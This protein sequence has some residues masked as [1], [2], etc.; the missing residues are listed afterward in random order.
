MKKK[1]LILFT[2]AALVFPSTVFAATKSGGYVIRNDSFTWAISTLNVTYNSSTKKVYGGDVEWRYKY[3]LGKKFNT[4]VTKVDTY[5]CSAY[6]TAT[7]GGEKRSGNWTVR[8][9]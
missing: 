2:F 3:P 7:V 8:T 9:K 6:V 1:L 4:Y 5:Y